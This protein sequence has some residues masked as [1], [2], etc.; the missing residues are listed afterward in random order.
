MAAVGSALAA[1]QGKTPNGAANAAS[2]TVV[3]KSCGTRHVL[4]PHDPKGYDGHDFATTSWWERH[5]KGVRVYNTC[6]E[7][8]DPSKSLWIDWKTPGPHTYVPP[9]E[10]YTQPRMSTD[11]MP[12]K[13]VAGCLIYGD[14]RVPIRERFLGDNNDVESVQAEGDCS[15]L[16]GKRSLVAG[17]TVKSPWITMQGR[18]AMPSKA[19][20]IEG[21]L[22][23]FAYET[24][25]RPAEEGYEIVFAYKAAPVF[26][27]KFQGE[28]EGITFRS[29]PA[30]LHQAIIKMGHEDGAIRLRGYEAT[31]AIPMELPKELRAGEARLGFFD[32]DGTLVT[33]IHVPIL[34]PAS[35]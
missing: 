17:S 27:E 12:A 24:G 5:P 3:V 30:S 22:I 6:V 15:Q 34:L 31:I 25:L 35:P 18:A 13:T 29:Q 1:G 19:K 7:N 9:G 23:R 11:V 4:V 32:Q 10:A 8:H 20:D 33:E 26:P 21:T 16:R 14:H 28:I 2:P